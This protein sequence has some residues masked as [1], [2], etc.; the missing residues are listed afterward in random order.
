MFYFIVYQ[1]TNIFNRVAISAFSGR[2]EAGRLLSVLATTAT[3]SFP[4]H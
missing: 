1:C 3:R 2:R 4:K